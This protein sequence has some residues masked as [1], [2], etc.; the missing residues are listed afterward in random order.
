MSRYFRLTLFIP[1]ILQKQP[2]YEALSMKESCT[3]Q[4][5]LK[6]K[7]SS[8]FLLVSVFIGCAVSEQLQQLLTV[9][10]ERPR[11][12]AHADPAVPR[13]RE[14]RPRPVQQPVPVHPGH[15]PALHAE[16]AAHQGRRAHVPASASHRA[17]PLR[18]LRTV[19]ILTSKYLLG[20]RI[21]RCPC[22]RFSG[23]V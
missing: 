8:V 1:R 10:Q 2:I 18:P 16:Q 3:Q 12:H 9:F 13:V 22:R 6:L 5:R 14:L 17:A 20:N 7:T 23:A 15:D 21:L 19:S 11:I 4:K